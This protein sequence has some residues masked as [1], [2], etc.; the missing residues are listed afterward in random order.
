[1]SRV[2]FVPRAVRLALLA[3][4]AWAPF[5]HAQSPSS[6]P[7]APV[8]LTTQQIEAGMSSAR[9]H[10]F[11]WRISKGGHA[12]YLYGTIHLAKLEWMFPGPTV[13][14][15]LHESDTVALEIDL[16]DPDVQHRLRDGMAA[17]RGFALPEPIVER[18]GR[19]M[20]AECVEPETMAKMGPELQVASLTVLAARR[21]GLD[22]SYSI[23]LMLSG[24]GR[25]A[26]KSMISLETPETQLQALQLPSRDEA[27]E[28]VTGALDDLETGRSRP[29][30][31][32]LAA[33]WAA[34]DHA[35]L[36]RYDAWCECRK[37]P[38]ERQAMKRLLDDRNPGLADSID[39]LHS[40]GRTVFAA[41]GSLHMVGPLGLPAQMARRGY[42]V[43]LG[44]F[45][46]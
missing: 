12:S 35:E 16:L 10:G 36:A 3:A 24:F 8:E 28:F 14:D 33:V 25:S 5:S 46:R 21:D 9:D 26:H 23:D 15:A 34:G 6:C 43:E 22:P 31:N 11:L 18:L 40:S 38:A 19:R 30:L 39:A 45:E 2:T 4:L 17:E 7:P 20:A 29:L 13:L 1:M 32:R 44:E 41:V 37:T 27:I 42:K